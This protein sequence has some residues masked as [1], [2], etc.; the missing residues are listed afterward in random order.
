MH[1]LGRL[2]LHINP[3]FWEPVV[4][5]ILI[6]VSV[7]AT[8]KEASATSCA[9]DEYE[10]KRLSLVEVVAIEGISMG[11]DELNKWALE[12]EVGVVNHLGNV[13]L[14]CPYARESWWLEPSS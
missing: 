3:R 4:W 10:H 7:G 14:D 2:F 11:D 12:A 8:K 6:G 5:S 13:R 1:K 9:L